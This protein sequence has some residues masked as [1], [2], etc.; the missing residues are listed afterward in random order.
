MRKKRDKIKDWLTADGEFRFAGLD[1][2][3]IDNE[4]VIRVSEGVMPPVPGRL[5][6]EPEAVAERIETMLHGD[7]R[8]RMGREAL[9]TTGENSWDM[10][11]ARVL[12]VYEEIW[13]DQRPMK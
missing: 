13:A 11:V 6:V 1:L 7:V 3:E 2:P 5:R 8:E 10:A 4:P 9:K 12:N